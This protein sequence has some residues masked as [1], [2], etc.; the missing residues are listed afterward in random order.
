MCIRDSIGWALVMEY[1]VGNIYVAFSW[2]DYFTSF[3]EKLNIHLHDYF[4]CSYAEAKGAIEKLA[5]L[6][7]VEKVD[8][9]SKKAN[10]ELINAWNNSSAIG[11][12]RTVSYTHLTIAFF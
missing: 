4:T 9:L 8:F 1:S 12:I 7:T 6:N 10:V 2:S 3:L 5:G 11:G